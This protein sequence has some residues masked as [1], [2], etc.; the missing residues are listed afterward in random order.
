MLASPFK[1]DSRAQESMRFSKA[2]LSSVFKVLE[3]HEV[4]PALGSSEWLHSAPG[5]GWWKEH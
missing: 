5:L 3:M 2:D 1:S 4:D